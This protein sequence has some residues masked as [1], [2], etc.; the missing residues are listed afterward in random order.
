MVKVRPKLFLSNFTNPTS[1]KK[2]NMKD[3]NMSLVLLPHQIFILPL[4][5][6][7]AMS[8]GFLSDFLILDDAYL[9]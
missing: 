6:K 5:Y 7:S 2:S 8:Q 3:F 4:D 9:R 1:D